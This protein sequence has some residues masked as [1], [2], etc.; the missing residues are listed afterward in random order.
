MRDEE[1]EEEAITWHV[2]TSIGHFLYTKNY[3]CTVLIMVLNST[4]HKMASIALMFFLFFIFR[5]LLFVSFLFFFYFLFLFSTRKCD[6]F[7]KFFYDLTVS[8]TQFFYTWISPFILTTDISVCVCVN[9]FTFDSHYS[10][11]THNGLTFV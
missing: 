4:I 11:Q 3:N 5:Y 1:E 7:T 9:E 6:D 8:A 2:V 10:W